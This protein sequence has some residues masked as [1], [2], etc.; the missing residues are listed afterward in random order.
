VSLQQACTFYDSCL[1]MEDVA[2]R[3]KSLGSLNT[4]I[5]SNKS[6]EVV[7]VLN[8][9]TLQGREPLSSYLR[10]WQKLQLSRMEQRSS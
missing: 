9:L 5:P 3:W 10:P 6:L 1:P 2:E 7:G 8:H 4:L